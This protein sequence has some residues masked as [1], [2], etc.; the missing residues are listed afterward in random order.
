[1]TRILRIGLCDECP[2]A[3]GSRACRKSSYIDEHEWWVFRRFEDYP[4]IPD[5]CP[6]EQD[7]PDWRPNE[8]GRSS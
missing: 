1:M 4:V 2:A 6:L 3:L 5:W 8:G 7:G